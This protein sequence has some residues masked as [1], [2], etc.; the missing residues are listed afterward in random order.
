LRTDASNCDTVHKHIWTTTQ[1]ASIGLF[2]NA[3]LHAIVL[4]EF[5]VSEVEVQVSLSATAGCFHR[6]ST[7]TFC[8]HDGNT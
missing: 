6:R 8:Q 2:V 7:T 5:D 1:G 4:A 3:N